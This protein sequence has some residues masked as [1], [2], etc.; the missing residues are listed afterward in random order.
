MTSAHVLRPAQEKHTSLC[1]N[2]SALR[3]H[4]SSVKG[5]LSFVVKSLVLTWLDG[6]RIYA[7]KKKKTTDES[8]AD[9]R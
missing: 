2:H 5:G 1:I 8:S 3:S 6:T 4:I 9:K 7:K